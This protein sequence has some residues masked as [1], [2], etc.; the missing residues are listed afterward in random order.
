MTLSIEDLGELLIN[1]T[2]YRCNSETCS[3]NGG[4]CTLFIPCMFD[5]P[6]NGKEG[7]SYP[8]HFDDDE[9]D[10]KWVKV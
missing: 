1:S 3:D 10:C 7:C 6:Q 5:E 9:C 8:E 2:I 4:V